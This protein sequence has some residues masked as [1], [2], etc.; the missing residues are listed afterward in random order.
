MLISFGALVVVVM[1]R[2]DAAGA[3]AAPAA[4]AAHAARAAPADSRRP[5]Q[6]L[7]PRLCP[8]PAPHRAQRVLPCPAIPAPQNVYTAQLAA[9]LTI[10]QFKS[11][12]RSIADLR[13]R[14]TGCTAVYQSRLLAASLVPAVYRDG[15]AKRAWM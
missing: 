10:G 6:H 7:P 1:V 14:A 11:A 2:G 4:P 13:G 8:D 12:I 15:W 3:A 5:A 9:F